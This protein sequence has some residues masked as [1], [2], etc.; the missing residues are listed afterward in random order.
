MCIGGYDP[1]GAAVPAFTSSPGC[2][3]G[4]DGTRT[5]AGASATSTVSGVTLKN[6]A[7][8]CEFGGWASVTPDP[9]TAYFR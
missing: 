6:C 3:G 1:T 4:M 8:A 5:V 2:T 7:K 9:P